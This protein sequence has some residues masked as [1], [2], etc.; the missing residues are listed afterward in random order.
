[1]SQGDSFVRPRLSTSLGVEMF[2][3]F[4]K[5][6]NRS[7]RL[8]AMAVVPVNLSEFRKAAVG[9]TSDR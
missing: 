6:F 4:K 2:W 1:M 8:V 3:I 5:K 7:I 9:A